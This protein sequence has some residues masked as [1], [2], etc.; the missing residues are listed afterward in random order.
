MSSNAEIYKCFI[1]VPSFLF[2]NY[3]LLINDIDSRFE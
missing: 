2:D 3:L 1:I